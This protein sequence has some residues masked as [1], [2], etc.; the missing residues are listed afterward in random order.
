MNKTLNRSPEPQP[1]PYAEYRRK[2]RGIMIDLATTFRKAG[3][4]SYRR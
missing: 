2:Y 4:L 1:D 3:S